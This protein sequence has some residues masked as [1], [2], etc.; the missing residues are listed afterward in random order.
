VYDAV[1]DE[2]GTLTFNELRRSRMAN[3]RFGACRPVREV[4][5]KRRGTPAGRAVDDRYPLDAAAGVGDVVVDQYEWRD[6]DH[7][8]AVVP[9][10]VWENSDS[11]VL[12]RRW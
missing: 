10:S 1:G 11:S 9:V 7:G 5:R 12:V 3:V 6:V 8:H 4:E 2:A